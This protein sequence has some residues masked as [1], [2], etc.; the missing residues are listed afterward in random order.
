M[1]N[2]T[3][4]VKSEKRPRFIK[5]GAAAEILSVSKNTIR[6]AVRRGDLPGI[7]LGSQVLVSRE[8]LDRLVAPALEAGQPQ[9]A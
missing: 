9:P 7:V 2:Q 6:A 8:G 5:T 1:P 3:A 4:S